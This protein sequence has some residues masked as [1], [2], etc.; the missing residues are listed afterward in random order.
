MDPG[1]MMPTSMTNPKGKAYDFVFIGAGLIPILEAVHQSRCGKSVLMVDCQ[2]ELGGA[3]LSKDL[4]GV[5]DV[6][7]A[8]HY[9]LPDRL[10]PVF[11]K[12]VLNWD[13]IPSPRKYR[14]FNVP[15]LGRCKS[16]YDSKLSRIAA[17]MV[18]EPGVGGFCAAFRDAF[19]REATRSYYIGGGA[20]EMLHKIRPIL[21]NSN[22]EIRYST[23]IDRIHIDLAAGQVES[24]AGAEVI[25]SRTIVISHGA[26]INELTSTKGPYPIEQKSLPRPAAHMFLRDDFSSDM[27]ECIFTGDPIVKYAHDVTRFTREAPQLLGKKKMIVLAFKHDIQNGADL[28]PAVLEKLKWAGMAGPDAVLEGSQWWDIML[29]SLDDADLDRMKAEFDPQ[30]DVLK[31]DNFGAG[32]GLY[33]ERWAATIKSQPEEMKLRVA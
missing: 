29:P 33:A 25:R 8:I 3:W 12:D 6:E 7:N 32:I 23:F 31:T 13:V 5:T 27:Y 19:L 22:V 9:M 21:A 24:H 17:R 10:G 30:V 16:P 18:E 2:A 20:P 26:K 14:V 1:S 28:F 11:M 15:G 4:F